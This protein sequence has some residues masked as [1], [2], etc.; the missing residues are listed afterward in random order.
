LERR[1]ADLQRDIDKITDYLLR[2]IGDEA[3][4][5]NRQKS[6]VAEKKEFE[7]KLATTGGDEPTN[8]IDIHPAALKHVLASAIELCNLMKRGDLSGD[9]AASEAFRFFD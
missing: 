6:L 8:V 5:D 9:H 4:L 3:T 2:G 1:V 7:A